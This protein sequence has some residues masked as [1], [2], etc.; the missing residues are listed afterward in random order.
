MAFHLH[1][2][3]LTS[4][5]LLCTAVFVRAETLEQVTAEALRNN[6]ELRVLEQAVA[7]AKGG[8]TTARSY[9]NPELTFAP[10]LKRVHESGGSKSEFHGVFELSQLFKFPGKRA[11]EIAIAR[12]DVRAQEIARDA[13]RF[14]L[15]TQVRRTFYEALAAQ[16]MLAVRD[17]EAASAQAFA[18]SAQKRVESGF[19]GDFETIKGQ[20]DLIEARKAKQEAEGRLASARV[21]LNTLLGRLP[22]AP[23][24]ISGALENLAPLGSLRDFTALA[25]ARNPAL[26][27]QNTEAEK[28]GLNLRLSRFGNR[29][30]FAVG[31][32]VEYSETEQIFGLSATIALPFWDR[33]KGE[34]ETTSAEQRKALAELEKLRLEISSEVTKAALNLQLAQEQL[35]LYSP[36]FLDRLKSFIR[37]AEQSYAQNATTLIIYLDAK[38]TYFDTL[39]DYY[40]TLG[41]V[42]Q[43]R[44]EL[45]SA[46]GVPLELKP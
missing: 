43:S 20:A 46:I 1:I 38:R 22:A 11:L 15:A 2:P 29:P 10:G 39:T 5:A 26:L 12:R 44:A 7:A 19:A 23:L 21:T 28:S 41:H 27:A 40:E 14:Q 3:K 8:V 45:E 25:L 34:I 16:K 9:P 33:K 6:P 36:E 35:A 42:A 4:V 32:S 37:R 31:P 17:E 18:A 24:L 30:D 13:L